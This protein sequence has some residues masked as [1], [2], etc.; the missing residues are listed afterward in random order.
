MSEYQYYEFAAIDKP[1]TATQME[2]L[3]A[4]SSRATITPGN[5][6][7]HYSW[8]NLKGDPLD[9]M[10]RYFDAHVYVANWCSCWLYLKLPKD[11]LDAGTLN[12]FTTQ[13][14]LTVDQK[15]EH[16]ILQWALSESEDYDRFGGEDGSGWMAR[17]LPLRDEL[18]RGDLRA[19]YLGWLAGVTYREVEDDEVEPALP[20]GISRLTAAQLSL[21]QF[22]EIDT[23]LLTAAGASDTDAP[24]N[25]ARCQGDDGDEYAQD[26]WLAGLPENERTSALKLL[27]SGA[28]QQAERQLKLA[29][30]SW[31]RARCPAG[32]P[33]APRR[34]VAQLR[35]LAEAAAQA[36]KQRNAAKRKQA[37]AQSR[38]KRE[39]YLRTMAAH[40]D[41]HWQSAEKGAERGGASGYDD[42]KRTLADLAEAYTLCATSEN[43]NRELAKFM[44]R[45]GKR[46]AL[47]RRLVE[48]G[49]WTKPHGR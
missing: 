22:L 31:Q 41:L 4:R 3:R 42:V 21:V 20:P 33:I 16:C 17:L 2:E 47:V 32:E 25:N 48:A 9:W 23:D 8:G 29:F 43:F 1:L 30:L 10:R 11:V 46:T 45:H 6:S 40:F 14:A 27:L 36:R 39:T 35:E 5:F 44:G 38:A 12:G 37:E 18:L 34:T 7:N 28:G 24:G 13:D 26:A 19:L 15:G 49:L